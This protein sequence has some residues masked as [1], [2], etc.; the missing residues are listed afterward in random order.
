MVDPTHIS[1]ILHNH[2][3][4]VREIPFIPADRELRAYVEAYSLDRTPITI[5]SPLEGSSREWKAKIKGVSMKKVHEITRLA[6]YIHS[7]PSNISRDYVVDVGSGQGYLH[8]VLTAKAILA[9]DSDE[10]QTTGAEAREKVTDTRGRVTHKT[11]DIAPDSLITAIDEWV[12]SFS[13]DTSPEERIP[14]LMVA[15]HACGSLHID[16]FQAFIRADREGTRDRRWHF[17]AAVTVPCCYNLLRP[18]HFP[19]SSQG[20][21]LLHGFGLPNPLPASAYHLAAQGKLEERNK[22]K[23]ELGVRKVIWRALVGPILGDAA[24]F[25]ASPILA[26]VGTREFIAPSEFSAYKNAKAPTPRRNLRTIAAPTFRSLTTSI[27]PS[28]STSRSPATENEF[29]IGNDTSNTGTSVLFQRLGKLP[30]SAYESWDLFMQHVEE[31]LYSSRDTSNSSC[32][33]CHVSESSNLIQNKLPRSHSLYSDASDPPNSARARELERL[34]LA[35]CS[36]GSVVESAILK[37]R[38][39]WIEEQ[40]AESSVTWE[41]SLVSL[42]DQKMGSARNNGIVVI[43]KSA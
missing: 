25:M 31:R 11:L 7:L 16:A 6:S 41:I 43:P 24:T 42:F 21:A 22:Q 1:R 35:R 29:D 3:N 32:L 20:D 2:P 26:G 40:L 38:Q 17:S 4:Q 28:D 12:E 30:N 15:L 19:I 23:W 36:L 10:Y 5:Q 37:D 33:G 39:K 27:D 13:P 34:H 14:V 9:L 8:R 18:D